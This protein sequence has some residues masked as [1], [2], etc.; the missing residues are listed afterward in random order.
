MG[1]SVSV[2]KD[3]VDLREIFGLG[4]SPP[5][6]FGGFPAE[7]CAR[8]HVKAW[9][10]EK[11]GN[12]VA[13][14]PLVLCDEQ[15]LFAAELQ[16]ICSYMILH[17]QLEGAA[18][19]GSDESLGAGSSSNGSGAG[20][21]AGA[22]E[23]LAARA[24]AS[25]TPRGLTIEVVSHSEAI[26]VDGRADGP[27]GSGPL[28]IYAIF[29]W[30][31]LH[32][33]PH[34][35]AHAFTK[36]FELERA[37]RLGLL[38]RRVFLETVEHAVRLK[39]LQG[40]DPCQ[41]AGESLWWAPKAN[42]NGLLTAILGGSAPGG[43]GGGGTGGGS[44]VLGAAVGRP[45]VDGHSTSQRFPR[46]GLS[47]CKSLGMA[48]A[49]AWPDPRST[50]ALPCAQ[51]CAQP[52]VGGVGVVPRLP[53]ATALDL[54]ALPERGGDA[55]GTCM[56][57]DGGSTDASELVGRKRFRGPDV[58]RTARGGPPIR[59]GTSVTSQMTP[60]PSTSRGAAPA[61]ATPLP[62]LN[63]AAVS[64]R[65]DPL[66]NRCDGPAMLNL[67]EINMSEEELI[68]SYD[69]EN[70]ENNYHL[71]H[72]L[73]KQLQLKQYR[74][75]CSEIVE[76]AVYLSSYQVAS[77]L[78]C[79]RK[80]RITHIV[81]TA[82][83]ICDNCF[84]DQFQYLTYYLKDTNYEE[85]SLLFY[86]TFD[87]IQN[88]ISRSGCVLVHCKEGVSRSSTMVLAYLM[89]RFSISFETAHER[90]RKV[91]PICN[92]NTGFTC[93][94]LLLGKKLG[95]SGQRAQATP[96]ADR[97]SI[98]RVGPH[99]PKE[100]FLLLLPFDISDPT[101]RPLFDPRFGWVVSRGEQLVLWLGSQVPDREATKAAVAQHARWLEKF[102]RCQC[103]LVVC[104]EGAEAPELWHALGVQAPLADD[105]CQ[106][107]AAPR[108][109]F[110]GDFEVLRAES[111]ASTG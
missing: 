65:K 79:L 101:V 84:P 23:E 60:P 21:L 12:S 94:L 38:R 20:N 104:S 14:S 10:F 93:Q 83:D 17:V 62:A 35:K 36:A 58:Q 86:R 92:P 53:L 75:A 99:N 50:S 16:K 49:D 73:Y 78:E 44:N 13:D 96:V 80:H 31:G 77:N 6:G 59:C 100:P 22:I 28:L 106:A 56:D 27:N 48:P 105:D 7:G 3:A 109:C 90:V 32:V 4:H 55:L 2:D 9:K 63:L 85:I 88:A 41:G 81:N 19:G 51:Q 68:N 37:M 111:E 26:P 8:H 45:G 39:G 102:E 64:A 91:R 43:R 33:D 25:C 30:H 108:Q 74:N 29:V 1:H 76:K 42:G 47:V 72:H 66:V 82:A 40:M 89:W 107:L 97:I 24:S 46:L 34:V 71:P 15:G 18:G 52:V 87:W 61:G 11:Q 70:E 67:E 98:Y 69:P 57:V 110:N 103:T 95:L 5:R 54:S